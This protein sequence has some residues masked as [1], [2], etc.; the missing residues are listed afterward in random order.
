MNYKYHR[1]TCGAEITDK[2]DSTDSNNDDD[3]ENSTDNRIII[4]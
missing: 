3:Y 1:P 4:M 2:N